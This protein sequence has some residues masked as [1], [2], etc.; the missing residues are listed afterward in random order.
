MKNESVTL[1]EIQQTELE[2]LVFFRDFCKEN[3]LKYFITAGTLLGAVRHGG[4]IPWDDDVDVVMLREDYD[5]FISLMHRNG[6][7]KYIFQDG[8]TDKKYP[9]YCPKLR[10]KKYIV[11]EKLFGKALK[12]NGCYIDIL[13]L[14]NCP[15]D[16]QAA[17][18]FFDMNVFLT[19]ALVKKVNPE[20]TVG[21]TKKLTRKLHK[22]TC[23]L[24]KSVIRLLREILR[25]SV[26][27]K[28]L[29]TVD[30][31]HGYPREVYEKEW[32]S[33]S[34]P[35]EF[36]GEVFSAP[37]GWDNLLKN[38]YG[39]YSEPPQE[40]KREGHFIIIERAEERS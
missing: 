18:T 13:P 40:D 37:I 29:C 2:I 22:L 20:Y 12:N 17:R 21:Y 39:N 5:R 9:I 14:D 6:A 26:E 4:F 27:G 34:V 38:M 23:L 36:E 25:R 30:G 19:T 31:A 16:S 1:K 10:E 32:F 11:H 33:E 24:P 35:M 7:G 28:L 3:G 15:E 8:K